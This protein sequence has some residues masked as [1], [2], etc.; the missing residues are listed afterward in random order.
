MA[1]HVENSVLIRNLDKKGNEVLES[2]FKSL[3]DYPLGSHWDL[4][5]YFKKG[6]DEELHETHYAYAI[7]TM[8]AKWVNL[9]NIWKELGYYKSFELL[10][11]WSVPVD[12]LQNI[13]EKIHAVCP[14]ATFGV[15]FEDEFHNFLGYMT[16]RDG[17][18]EDEEWIHSET[19]VEELINIDED[20]KDKL[21]GEGWFNIEDE[22]TQDAVWEAEYQL[23]E[24]VDNAMIWQLDQYDREYLEENSNG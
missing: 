7:N 4:Y 12:A 3:D 13:F 18:F 11:A 2:I 24:N 22:E 6:F 16:W 20:L 23:L 5:D 21:D 17:D 14:R 8:G 19:L 15:K 10:S 9:R 1:N